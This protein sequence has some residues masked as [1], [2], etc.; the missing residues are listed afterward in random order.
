M[1]LYTRLG[2]GMVIAAVL[3]GP[4]IAW[5]E[6]A[7]GTPLHLAAPGQEMTL[8]AMGLK[9]GRLVPVAA[10]P[11]AGS[12]LVTII[13]DLGKE[14]APRVATFDMDPYP[15]RAPDFKVMARGADERSPRPLYSTG[16][17]TWRS[18]A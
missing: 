2:L 10:G 15:L 9:G 14:G 7:P 4:S 12:P 18:R 17:V 1:A 6:D 3:A 5:G 16:S 8:R 11:V 13:V